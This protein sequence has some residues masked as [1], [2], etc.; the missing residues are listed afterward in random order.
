[1]TCHSIL[2]P[3]LHL[4]DNSSLTTSRQIVRRAASL[5]SPPNPSLLNTGHRGAFRARNINL[6]ARHIVII[7]ELEITWYAVDRTD[8]ICLHLE[9]KPDRYTVSVG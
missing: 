5:K 9:L 6:Q 7:S 2:N 8:T 4:Y 3:N 1:M